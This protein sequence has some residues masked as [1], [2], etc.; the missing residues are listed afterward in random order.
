MGFASDRITN[1]RIIMDNWDLE[2]TITRI[3]WD[4][5]GDVPSGNQT[6]LENPLYMG[7]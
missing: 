2:S 7:V 3:Q 4:M 5:N 6:W 1:S